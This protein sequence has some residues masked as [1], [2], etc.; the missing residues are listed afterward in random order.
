MSD[1]TDIF[2]DDECEPCWLCGQPTPVEIG[3]CQSCGADQEMDLDDTDVYD[4]EDLDD[5]DTDCCSS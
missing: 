2:D 5:D 1:M 4:Y 3:I